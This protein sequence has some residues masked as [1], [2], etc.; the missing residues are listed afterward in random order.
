MLISITTLSPAATETVVPNEAVDINLP[1]QVPPEQLVSLVVAKN[2]LVTE[3]QLELTAEKI[4]GP[5]FA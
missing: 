5:L 2:I 4:T 3:F 1:I